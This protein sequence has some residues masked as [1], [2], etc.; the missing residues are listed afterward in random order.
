MANIDRYLFAIRQARRWSYNLSVAVAPDTNL[1]AGPTVTQIDIFGLPFDLSDQARKHSGVGAAVD[2]GGEWAAPI[3]PGTR[4]HAGLQFHSL[5]YPNQ[6]YDDMTLSAWLGPEFILKRW[7]ISPRATAFRRW[8]GGHTYNDGAGGSLGGVYYLNSRFGLTGS[9]GGQAMRYPQQSAQ[10][11]IAAS[12]GL[13][14]FYTPTPVSV[15]R[16]NLAVTRQSAE[17]DAYA[18][19]AVQASIGYDRDLP[20]GF[21][22]TVEPGFTWIHYDARLAAFPVVRTDRQWTAQV[23]LL[24]RRIDVAGFTPR[25]LYAYT[26]NDSDIPLYSFERNR[27]EIGVTR[28]F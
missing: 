27:F 26:R 12:I 21:S 9:V 5:A 28:I 24:N 15:V 4:L 10:S 7:D 2:A 19:R 3:G 11:G 16:G 20:G 23:T 1:N 14:A 22:A 8:Y 6:A 18:Y 25:F 17:L 13:G